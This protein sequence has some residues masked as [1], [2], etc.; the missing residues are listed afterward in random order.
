MNY[1]GFVLKYECDCG[2]KTPEAKS[3]CIYCHRPNPDRQA[4]P[5]FMASPVSRK[6]VV[7]N[8]ERLREK[9]LQEALAK[10]GK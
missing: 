9:K 7:D 8:R 5:S 4:S 1:R 10:L 2:R 6:S 3:H